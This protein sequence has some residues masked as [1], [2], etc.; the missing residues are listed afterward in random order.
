MFAAGVQG[1]PTLPRWEVSHDT[2][3]NADPFGVREFYDQYYYSDYSYQEEM[4]DPAT[5][6]FFDCRSNPLLCYELARV[7]KKMVNPTKS[8][9]AIFAQISNTVSPT[10]PHWPSPSIPSIVIEWVGFW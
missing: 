8:T 4:Q 10:A 9:S 7:P 1:T 2:A 3:Y 6:Q 5:G